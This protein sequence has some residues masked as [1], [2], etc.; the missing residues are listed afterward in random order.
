MTTMLALKKQQGLR[1][2]G[3]LAACAL[4][5]GAASAQ[6]QT[7]SPRIRS[8][9]SMSDLTAL[10][11]SPRPSAVRI[12]AGRMPADTRLTGITLVFNRTAAQQADLNALLAAQQNPAS[13]LFHK[14]LTPEQFGARF[15]MAQADLDKV[16]QW[17][18]Q[19]GFTVDWVAR[20]RDMIR[21]SGTAN[22]VNLAFQTEMHYFKG[23]DSVQHIGPA[24]ALYLP[25]AIA[26]T[27]EAI[28]DLVDLRPRST[29]SSVNRIAHPEYTLNNNGTQYVLFA[30]GDIKVAYDV[31]SLITGGFTG[32]GQT[33]AVMGQSEISATDIT[34]FQ[35]AAGLTEK[36]PN[37]ILVPA[38]G[39]PAFS[40]GDEGESD[41]DVEWSGAMAPG[42][43]VDFVYTGNS[44][45]SNGVFDSIAYAV[46]SQLGDI[47][48]VSY[49]SCETELALDAFDQESTYQEAEAQGQS[50]IA[51]SGDF[52]STACYGFSN[53][54]TTQQQALA[55][56][57]PASSAY[58]TGIGGTEIS[59]ANDAVGTYWGSAATNSVTLT[60]ALSY[61]PEIAWNDDAVAGQYAPSAGGGLSAG[62]GGVSTLYT[63]KPSWQTGV[64]GI[65]TDGKR[66][67]PD[68]AL[69]SSPDY[70][71]YLFCSSDQ[72]DWSSSQTG[73]CGNSEFYDS[74][75]GYFTVAGGTSFAAPIF[76]GMV[77]I[78]NQK[79]GYATGQGLLNPSLYTLA[80]NSVTYA[81]AFHDVTTGN[82]YCTAGTTYGYCSASG[83][84]EGYPAGTGYD[85]VTGLGSVD[86]ANLANAWTASTSTL[87]GT[88]TVLSAATNSPTAN[89]A[90]NVTIAVSSDTG[91]TV[92]TGMVSVSVNGGTATSYTLTGNGTYVDALT[93]ASAGSYTIV[94]QYAGDSTHAASTGAL[95]VTVGGSST[96]TGSITLAAT[97]ITVAQG[98]SGGSTVTV[99]P[100]GGYTGTVTFQVTTSSSELQTYGCYNVA[101]A[102]VSGTTAA[103]TTVTVYTSASDCSSSGISKRATMHRFAGAG[104][105]ASH[106]PPAPRGKT[107][108]VGLAAL[109]GVLLLG[110]RRRAKWI[111]M[112][113][114][115]LLLAGAGLAIGC[116]GGGSSGGGSTNNN[117][118]PK[119]AYTLGVTGTDTVSTSITSSTTFTL[120]VD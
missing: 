13:P 27:V 68:V 74:S 59:S 94:A 70:P 49:G 30:P 88:T 37:M 78:I 109:A 119:G 4:A 99:T 11:N 40:A 21:F 55:V 48:T 17:L 20:G 103:T 111:T 34:N 14:W 87:I 80:S 118:V 39:T 23:P 61:I 76:A 67:V 2:C 56:S 79:A 38:T 85:L 100:A 54:T 42:A 32:T 12:D 81:S 120:T 57:Y 69:Y 25:S 72:S 110:L 1:V 7:P 117:Y 96:G 58:V 105:A 97:S 86:L 89:V 6:T 66:D 35:D 104:V 108:P 98:S 50:I 45:N 46:D 95:T 52:G 36:T 28:H 16:E 15:G 75:S 5:A 64:P 107:L 82:N 29:H 22:Q 71:G 43:T 112:V 8:E 44:G 102:T 114:C 106:E 92:P 10:K 116:G 41:L 53:L 9:V 84:T 115:L 113:G 83:A 73:S 65:P 77:A 47:I 3:W 91:S 18:E 26:P 31:N 90:D 63:S 60:T 33:I 51:S 62:G 93:F 24:T 101:N 19:Q